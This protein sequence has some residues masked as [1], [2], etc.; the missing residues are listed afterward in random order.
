MSSAA[1]A[2]DEELVL[3]GGSS[4][5]EDA[6]GAVEELS[7]MLHGARLE[8]GGRDPSDRCVRVEEGTCILQWLVFPIV[9]QHA[10]ARADS[11]PPSR[12]GGARQQELGRG[13]TA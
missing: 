6:K 5:D 13:G 7:R 4:D 8:E 1:S 3:S 10:T 12:L 11:P 2:F 9:P